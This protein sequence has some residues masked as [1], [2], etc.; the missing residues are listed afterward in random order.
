MDC[1]VNKAGGQIQ[2][3]D[4]C[5]TGSLVSSMRATNPASKIH[6]L[7]KVASMLSLPVLIS[8]SR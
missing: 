2:V 5:G 1:Y 6:F 8:V 7:R 4:A 3:G